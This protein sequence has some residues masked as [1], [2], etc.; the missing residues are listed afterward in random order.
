MASSA[1]AFTAIILTFARMV[2]F[3]I[4]FLNFLFV[5]NLI[6]CDEGVNEEEDGSNDE[7]A[8]KRVE[9][10]LAAELH[11]G[12]IAERQIERAQVHQTIEQLQVCVEAYR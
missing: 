10:E 1:T 7:Q 6:G 2:L 8:L 4:L 9:R 11:R 3:R 5:Q 12:Q